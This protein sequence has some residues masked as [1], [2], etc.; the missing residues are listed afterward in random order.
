VP[1]SGST[2]ALLGLALAGVEAL[3]RKIR[4]AR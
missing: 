2:V 3:R 1:D 4:T